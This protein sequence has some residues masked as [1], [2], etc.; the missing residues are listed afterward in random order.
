[1]FLANKKDS[2]DIIEAIC[3]TPHEPALK[4]LGEKDNKLYL[5]ELKSGGLYSSITDK[6]IEAEKIGYFCYTDK[7]IFFPVEKGMRDKGFKLS[8]I[9][10]DTKILRTFY[11]DLEFDAYSFDSIGIGLIGVLSRVSGK[12][13]KTNNC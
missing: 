8:L 5:R 13:Y 6:L 12:L 1:M 10:L 9:E 3:K 11:P 2:K 7:E 4:L